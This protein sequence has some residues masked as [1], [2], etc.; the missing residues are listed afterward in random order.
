MRS[1]KSYYDVIVVGSGAAGMAAGLTAIQDGHSVLLLE[2]G[3]TTGGST[4]Y[5]E[6]LFAINSYLQQERGI[7]INATDVL[8]EEVNYSKYK[9]DSRI[10]R[11]YINSSAEN[12]QWLH[13]QGVEYEGVQAMG[14]GEAT[15]HIYKGMGYGVIH[16]V[17]QPRF[18]QNGG[19]VLTL[20]RAVNLAKKK[21]GNFEVT[22]LDNRTKERYK[23]VAQAVVLAT[24]GYL[25]NPRL[26]KQ[27]TS[28][29]EKRLVPVSSGKGTGDGLEMAWNIGAQKNGMGMAM[30]F[31]GYL[32][33][34]GEPSYKMMSSQMNTAAGQQPLLWVN[35]NGERF[36]NEEVVYNFSLAGNALY[37]QAQVFS[38]L[39]QAV[40][41]RMIT[42]G[43]F[44]GLGIYVR[45]GQKM[46]K[47]QEELDQA[48]A[49]NKSFILK[50][51]Q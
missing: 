31:G 2:K 46:D 21:D 48:V 42:K 12:V 17:L 39:D 4:N 8:S 13:D 14:A 25:N 36:V 49:S 3:K 26:I 45:R 11:N 38:I 37:T 9:A 51:T 47:L 30:L 33:D 28:Y 34:E 22:L 19:E 18:E 40:V 24:G 32:K 50:Q 5:T 16:D 35:E 27:E 7:K 1:K 6:G 29:D 15:W 43:N 23:V 41:D 10:W 20:T 44:M